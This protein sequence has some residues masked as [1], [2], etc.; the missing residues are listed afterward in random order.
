M[1]VTLGFDDILSE[2]L[3]TTDVTTVMMPYASAVFSR[4]VPGDRPKVV[5]G[6]AEN[7]AFLGQFTELPQDVVFTVEYSVHG[8]MHAVYRL[9][10]VG[11]KIR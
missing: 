9:F 5:P 2:V 7:F 11:K 3:A 4:R 6:R 8:A 1:G 10:S